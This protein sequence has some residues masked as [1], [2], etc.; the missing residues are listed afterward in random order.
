MPIAPLL[1]L[2]SQGETVISYH[3][4]CGASATVSLDAPLAAAL[5]EKLS[6]VFQQVIVDPAMPS[7]GVIDV[8]VGLKQIQ[9]EIPRPTTHSYPAT[10][11]VGLDVAFLAEDGSRLW[12]RKVK[13][14]GLGTVEVQEPSCEVAGLDAVVKEAAELVAEGVT[15]VAGESN[16]IREYAK[17]K[18]ASGGGVARPALPAAAAPLSAATVPA[19]SAEKPATAQAAVSGANQTGSASPVVT[20]RAIL[21]DENRD[22]I[23]QSDEPLTIELEVKNDGPAEVKGVEVTVGGSEALAVQLPSSIVIGDVQPG[24]IKRTTITKPVTGPNGPWRAELLLG[25][26]SSSSQAQMPPPKKFSLLMRPAGPDD[27]QAS[28]DIDQLPKAFSLLKQSKSVVIA[29]GVGRFRDSLVPPMKFAARDAEVMAA[30]LQSIGGLPADRVRLLVDGHALKQDLAETFE[31]WLPKHIDPATVVYVYIAG[32]ALVDGVTGAVS[33][34]PFDGS[35]ASVS[36]LYPV[37]R[38]Q[39]SLARLPIQRAI[40]MVDASLEH[41][42]GSDPATGA[43]PAWEVGATDASATMMWMIGNSGLQEAQAYE[44][45]RHGL[46]TYQLLKGLQG[47]ADLDRD[48]TVVAGELCTFARGEV[49]RMAGAQLRSRQDPVCL[50]AIGQ[51]AMIRIHPMAEGNN[52]KLELTVIKESSHK[53]EM[54]GAAPEGAGPGQ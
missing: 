33:F 6:R 8:A 17:A 15:R 38:L 47:P 45:G 43:S 44:Q 41:A 49:A 50:P 48:G 31:E 40:L 22:Q 28:T 21:R 1:R 29:I 34:V 53:E 12:T 2:S 36:R 9:L 46:F 32:R 30:Y 13:S 24:E 27:H 26:Q 7:D 3:N 4:A 25:L 11:T 37:R 23:L 19:R 14:S 20:F 5:Q 54:S 35:N 10:V 42:P 39:E 52:P 18:R 16:K 51:G